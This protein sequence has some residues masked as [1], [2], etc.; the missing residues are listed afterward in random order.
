M[1][2]NYR[3][4]DLNFK[5]ISFD[6]NKI[7]KFSNSLEEKNVTLPT[8]EEE[9]FLLNGDERD[10]D[11]LF[12]INTINFSYWPDKNK[13]KWQIN[14][15]DK[16]YSGSFGLF[17]ALKRGIENN[18]PLFDNKYLSQISEKDLKNILE[19]DIE[20]PMFDERLNILRDIGRNFID[21]NIESFSQ[22]LKES[23]NSCVT[24]IEKIISIF[25]SFRDIFYFND[26]KFHIL[27]RAQLICAMIHGRNRNIFYDIDKITVFSDYR[28]PQTLRKLGLIKYNLDLSEK[29]S[30]QTY[31]DQGSIEELEIRLSA[32]FCSEKIKETF[33]NKKYNSLYIDYFLWKDGQEIKEPDFDFHRT[34]SIYY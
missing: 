7:K 23:N 31:L 6:E 34:R 12:L 30:K 32:I 27:K 1:F 15:R 14:F 17:G 33:L 16:K 9:V 18:Y 3:N 20:I 25:P 5:N 11:F 21:N 10:L 4:R 19:D 13:Q 26:E 2:E 28:I 8:W 29:I 22:L 24:L